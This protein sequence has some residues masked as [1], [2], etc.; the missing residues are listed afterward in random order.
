[1]RIGW[2]VVCAALAG[3]CGARGAEGP[4]WPRSA[5]TERVGSARDDGGES[6]QPKLPKEVAAVESSEDD[7]AEPSTPVAT[8]AKPAEPGGGA[9]AG[10]ATPASTD[11][12][13]PV[14]LDFEEEIVIDVNPGP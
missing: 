6:L 9:G 8:A 13:Q 14:M 11:P 12:E 4:A 5:G 2:V 3:G 1:M 7:V 10:A